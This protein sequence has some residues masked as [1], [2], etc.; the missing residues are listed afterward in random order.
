MRAARAVPRPLPERP[1]GTPAPA[2]QYLCAGGLY[3]L[4]IAAGTFSLGHV[5]ARTLVPGDP[6]ATARLVASAEG[7]FRLGMVSDLVL[8]L[9][10]LLLPL[11]L[12]RTL[13]PLRPS[14][15]R[16]MVVLAILGFPLALANLGVKLDLLAAV[17]GGG[18]FGPLGGEALEAA[19]ARAM[20]A[21]RHGLLVQQVCWGAWLIPLGRLVALGGLRP[22]ALGYLLMAGG[23]GYLV[24]VA[25]TLGWGAY[26]ASALPRVV[27]L[28]A[29]LAEMGTC[30]ALL[31]HGLPLERLR[32]RRPGRA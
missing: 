24:H 26:A 31:A 1:P 30:V 4:V 8:A 9:S 27:R 14:V 23:A 3:L 20:Q 22:R 5:P 32:R 29:T 25:G 12:K 18:G 7:L 21:H 17:R 16:L 10:F 2:G 6:A 28:P 11:A 15:G 13:G 19:V